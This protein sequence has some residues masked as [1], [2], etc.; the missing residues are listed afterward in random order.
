MIIE[1]NL[2]NV[3]NTMSSYFNFHLRYLHSKYSPC[4]KLRTVMVILIDFFFESGDTE[5]NRI[6]RY[7]VIWISSRQKYRL[8]FKTSLKSA[9]NYLLYNCYFTFGSMFL[10]IDWN[11]DPAPFTANLF[12]CHHGRKWLLQTRKQDLG[13]SQHLPAQN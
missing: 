8:Y 2:N 10:V 1:L 7:G 4:H 12:L 3:Y 13:P 5:F 11:A 6:T 9:I